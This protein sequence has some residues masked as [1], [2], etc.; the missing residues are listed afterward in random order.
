[1]INNYNFQIY[2]IK[3]LWILLINAVIFLVILVMLVFIL[4]DRTVKSKSNWL[5]RDLLEY[6]CLKA[7]FSGPEIFGFQIISG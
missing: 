6:S 4:F 1:M 5:G 3:T 7:K 2:P